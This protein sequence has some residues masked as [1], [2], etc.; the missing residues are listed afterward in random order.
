EDYF[1]D[2]V[3]PA[4]VALTGFENENGEPLQP[5]TLASIEDVEITSLITWAYI[6]DGVRRNSLLAQILLPVLGAS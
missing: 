5:D 2:K 6:N 3:L 1:K 4:V